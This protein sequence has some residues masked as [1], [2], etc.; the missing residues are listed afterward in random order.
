MIDQRKSRELEQSYLFATQQIGDVLQRKLAAYE[1]QEGVSRLYHRL[2]EVGQSMLSAAD[3]RSLEQEYLNLTQELQGLLQRKAAT[4]SLHADLE[5]WHTQLINLGRELGWS[6]NDHG[7][8]ITMPSSPQDS[9]QEGGPVPAD[10]LARL[11]QQI[12][13]LR[14]T[15]A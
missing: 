9:Y 13:G 11:Q 14:T 7:A 10:R 1:L 2:I 6:G 4:Y 8:V 5:Q 15:L 12:E 3:P